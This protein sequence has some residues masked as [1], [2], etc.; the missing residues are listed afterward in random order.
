[1]TS[2]DTTSTTTHDYPDQPLGVPETSALFG[3]SVST[4][5]RMLAAGKLPNATKRKGPKG[6]EWVIPPTDMVA[7]GYSVGG[8]VPVPSAPNADLEAIRTDYERRLTELRATHDVEVGGIRAT[9]RAEVETL[10]QR[11]DYERQLRESQGQTLNVLTALV[12]QTRAGRRALA[13]SGQLELEAPG[14]QRRWSRK[15]ADPKPS[16]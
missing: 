2:D 5:R 16:E 1:M 11:A 8:P 9:H 13:R 14:K 3:V 10:T 15:P 4:L 6:D 7:A 12:S